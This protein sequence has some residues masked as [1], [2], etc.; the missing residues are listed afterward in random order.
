MKRSSTI[1]QYIKHK[2]LMLMF[3]PCAVLIFVFYYIPM[4][5]LVA[6]FKD[7][8]LSLG[9]IR[10]PW[11]G[12]DA[13]R[14]L[15]GSEEFPQVIRNTLVI[16]CLRISVGFIAPVVLA[17]MINELRLR[18]YA[19]F[20]QTATYLPYFFSWVVLGGMLQM[21]LSQ[22]GPLN[23]ALMRMGADP[24]PFF[25]NDTWFIFTL[26]VTGIWKTVGYGAVIYLAALAGIDP[27]LYEA[28]TIDGAG[29]WKQT[30]HITIPM[31]IPTIVVLFILS[32]GHILNAGFDQVY[33]LYN[34]SVYDVADIL[35][36]YVLRLLQS[37]DFGL[38]TAAGLFKSVVG[39]TLV[40]ATNYIS[41]KISKGEH[42][43]W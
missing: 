9:I 28:A 32:V 24:V 20:V 16:S 34:P 4:G 7:F 37:M 42:G 1:A 2:E 35:D 11:C 19:R 30:V 18:K 3:L 21:I 27:T 13:F 36:T 40:V 8:R 39:L 14:T 17:L 22:T 26:V 25:S 38:A 33:N 5:G 10:S 12:L 29:R 6:A 31:L 43:V 41:R 23:V 15:F